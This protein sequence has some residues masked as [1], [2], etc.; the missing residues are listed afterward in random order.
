MPPAQHAI[1][2]KTLLA[3]SHE[4]RSLR[5]SQAVVDTVAL[6]VAG[7]YARLVSRPEGLRADEADARLAEHG[8][9]VLAKDQRPS[10]FRLL[11]RALVNPL[12]ILLA[13]L[14][15]VSLSCLLYTSDAA[16]E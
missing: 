6:D 5:V 4:K 16:D 7:V 13:V 14:A 11:G 12:V 10:V 2:P 1:L 3:K 8:L 9:N 15:A